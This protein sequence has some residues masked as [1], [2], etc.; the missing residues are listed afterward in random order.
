LNPSLSS[1]KFKPAKQSEFKFEFKSANIK[2]MKKKKESNKKNRKRGSTWPQPI[3][4][5]QLASPT[6]AQATY[7][8]GIDQQVGPIGGESRLPPPDRGKQLG[9]ASPLLGRAKICAAALCRL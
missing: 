9:G 2:H 4:P 1:S 6:G 8:I 7:R 5:A 3:E